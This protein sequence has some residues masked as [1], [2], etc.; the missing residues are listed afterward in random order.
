VPGETSAPFFKIR[1]LLG[2]WW[3]ILL[4]API[5]EGEATVMLGRGFR[6]DTELAARIE[7]MPGVTAAS[8]APASM[9]LQAAA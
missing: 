6:L 5:E 1:E 8:L 2:T 7:E 9:K 4:H 3:R